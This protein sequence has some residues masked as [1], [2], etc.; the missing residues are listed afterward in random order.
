MTYR[1]W[2]HALGGKGRLLTGSRLDV[3]L[4]DDHHAE[5][6]EAPAVGVE[7]ERRVWL[8]SVIA[9]LEVLPKC[10]DRLRP[11]GARSLLASLADDASWC[12]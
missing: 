6:A 7:E 10:V 3:A 4:H 11:E 9:L 8:V 2:A 1:V 5:A 12:R